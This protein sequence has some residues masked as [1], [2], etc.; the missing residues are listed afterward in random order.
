MHALS[1]LVKSTIPNYLS[2]LPIPDSIGGW[3]KLGV[4]DWAALVPP[5]AVLA[6]FTYLTYRAF[7]PHGRPVPCKSINQNILKTNP[8]VVDTIDVEDIADKAVFCRCWKSKNWPYCDGAH[9][10]HN[11][12]TGD[13]VGPVVIKRKEK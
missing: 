3:F 7:C 6:G 2:G 8:K 4:R 11:K 13:N 9:G 1:S 12:E 5:T 10:A